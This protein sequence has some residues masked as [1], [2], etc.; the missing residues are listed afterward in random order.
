MSMNNTYKHVPSH[1]QPPQDPPPQ[2]QQYQPDPTDN[3]NHVDVNDAPGRTSMDLEDNHNTVNDE[4]HDDDNN[5]TASTAIVNNTTTTTT[6]TTTAAALST[7]DAMTHLIKGNLGPGCL[8]LPYVFC[9]TGWRL[10]SALLFVIAIQGTY[11]MMLL[12]ECKGVL[13][14]SGARRHHH[15]RHRHHRQ[16]TFMDVAQASLGRIGHSMVQILLFILQTGVCCVFLSLLVT[17]MRAT[18]FATALVPSRVPFVVLVTISLMMVCGL[19]R[20]LKDLRWLSTVA[21]VFMGFAIGTAT[22]AGWKH[23][24][25]LQQQEPNTDDDNHDGSASSSSSFTTNTNPWDVLN[26]ITSMFFSL[27]GIGLV[28]PVENGYCQP[29]TGDDTTLTTKK[30]HIFRYVILPAAMSIIT[31]LFLLVGVSASIGFPDISTGS[32]TAYLEE[33]YPNNIWYS[34]VNGMVMMSVFMT[35]PLQLTPAIEVLEEWWDIEID[36][37]VVN[38]NDNN[39]NNTNARYP[40]RV[41][42]ELD[43]MNTS[44][45]AA[46]TTTST[47]IRLDGYAQQQQQQQH[48]DDDDDDEP[49]FIQSD[50]RNDDEPAADYVEGP[51][52]EDVQQGPGAGYHDTRQYSYSYGLYLYH[53][54]GWIIRRCSVIM[55]CAGVVLVVHDLSTLVSFFGAIGQTG[56]AAMPCACH[57]AL[58]RQGMVPSHTGKTVANVVTIAFCVMVMVAG[59]IGSVLD[60]TKHG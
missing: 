40:G 11:S 20:N 6:T 29:S 39:N 42:L 1:E 3:N 44:I 33:Q 49:P 17:N 22:V 38:N 37:D 28:L 14:S 23:Y 10:G 15:P 26:F 35:F 25:Y 47:T 56:L 30:N 60:I 48:D 54:Y 46:T 43:H 45:I 52:L 5:N 27:E 21:N 34:L 4:D 9:G 12:T 13:V 8:N 7:T 50:N 36:E 32:I 2:R 16:C 58:Q 53:R 41:P 55:G 57:L 31:A 18:T 51:P 24:F 59:L 19:L